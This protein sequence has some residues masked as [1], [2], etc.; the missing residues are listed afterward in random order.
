[1][2]LLARDERSM[3]GIEKLRFF[4]L[5]VVGGHGS[6]L[7]EEGGRELLDLSAS[8]TAAGLGYG[9]PRVVEAVSA[10]IANQPGAGGISSVSATAVRLAE[11]LLDVTPVAQDD[12]RVYLGNCG[13]DANDVALRA[14]RMA[15]GRTRLLA[16]SGGY[17]GG[18]GVAMGV[19]G[20]HVEAGAA[21]EPDS[22]LLPYP[23]A[24]EQAAG[25]LTALDAELASGRVAAL[26]VEPIQSDGGIVVPPEGFLAAVVDRCRVAGVP[27]ICDEVKVG[28]GRTGHLQAFLHD[29]VRPDIVTYGKSLGGGL[30]L[31]AAVGPVSI[32]DGP[33]A[34]ALLTTAGNP[35]CAAA[36]SAVLATIADDGLVRRAAEL[37]ERMR[38]GLEQ[39]SP[40]GM[41]ALRG[42]GLSLGVPLVDADGAPSPDLARRASYRAWQLGAVVFY[43][44]GSVLEVTPPLVLTDHEADLGVE[45]IVQAIEEASLVTDAEVA[46]FAGW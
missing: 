14:C 41:G 46:P 43:V 19:S 3:A 36:G 44:G 39:A 22:A 6:W 10:A 42:R 20:V 32:L 25:S 31:S 24:P 28:L 15:T 1:M 45:L 21:A 38:R 27:V 18:L 4:P 29:G 17:H 8:W 9:H 7:V 2:S 13:S 16:F 26:I 35:V 23:S 33:S 40:P 12:A 30:P 5:A 37:G 34:S 11:E